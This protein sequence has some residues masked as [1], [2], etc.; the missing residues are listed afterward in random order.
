MGNT[1]KWEVEPGVFVED[2]IYDYAK[3]IQYE[4]YVFNAGSYLYRS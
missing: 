2:K 3:T 4:K 1:Q